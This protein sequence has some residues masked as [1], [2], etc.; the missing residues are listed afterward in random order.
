MMKSYEAGVCPNTECKS[1]SLTFG[2]REFNRDGDIE[3]PFTC[4]DCGCKGKEV[5]TVTY[6]ETISE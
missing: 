6:N 4:N 2:T 3:Y 5:Y 1:T